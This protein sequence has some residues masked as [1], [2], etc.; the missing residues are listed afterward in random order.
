MKDG[1]AVR[2]RGIA[3][4]QKNRA[5]LADVASR[6]GVSPVTVSRAIRHPE[7]VSEELRVRID[8]AVRSLNYI[9]NHLARALASTRTHIVGV[10]VPSLTNGVFE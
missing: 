8:D 9:P 4:N 2:G 5:T 1:H 10:V 7:M 3:V 6:A